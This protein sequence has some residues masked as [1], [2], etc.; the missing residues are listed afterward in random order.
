[1]LFVKQPA[2][3]RNLKRFQ[4]IIRTE[5]LTFEYTKNEPHHRYGSWNYLQFPKYVLFNLR[6]LYL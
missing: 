2:E 4:E 6:P 1:M 3:V 5:S